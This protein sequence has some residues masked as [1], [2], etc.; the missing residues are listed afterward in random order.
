M[1][2]KVLLRFLVGFPIGIAIGYLITIVISA[3]F[4]DGYYSPCVPELIDQ[5]GSG[6]NAV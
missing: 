5:T 1:L 2:K 4:A 6:I 3:I